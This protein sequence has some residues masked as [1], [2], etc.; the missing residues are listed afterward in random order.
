MQTHHSMHRG[1]CDLCYIS[2]RTFCMIN[3]ELSQ[4]Q[5]WSC[6][7]LNSDR[8]LIIM[9]HLFCSLK[10]RII[11]NKNEDHLG[12]LQH[13][14]QTLGHIKLNLVIG[15]TETN[16]LF[17]VVGECMIT[18]FLSIAKIQ[19]IKCNSYMKCIVCCRKQQNVY[20]IGHKDT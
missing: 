8:A 18:L 19:T 14:L 11:N 15:Q 12:P 4:L 2:Y 17:T 16:L 13:N 20:V 10:T 1:Y 9:L 6:K 7:G 5:S 3:N